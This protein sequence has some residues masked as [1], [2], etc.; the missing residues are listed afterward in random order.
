MKNQSMNYQEL[1]LVTHS[2]P[3]EKR[4]SGFVSNLNRIWHKIVQ[5]IVESNEPRLYS[6]KNRCGSPY[7]EIHDPI[8]G[9]RVFFSSEAEVRDWLDRRY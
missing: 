6:R 8:I 7:W 3:D 2:D 5:S 4:N 9:R 1:E